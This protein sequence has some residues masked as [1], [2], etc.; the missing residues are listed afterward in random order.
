M[1]LCNHGVSRRSLEKMKLKKATIMMK[2]KLVEEEE[3]DEEEVDEDGEEK[4]ENAVEMMM[5]GTPTKK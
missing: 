3:E 2:E 4:G 1:S 5:V